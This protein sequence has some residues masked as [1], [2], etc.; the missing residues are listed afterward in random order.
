MRQ[1]KNTKIKKRT[2]RH[3]K[4]RARISGV[5]RTPRLSVFR[6]NKYIYAQLIDDSKG[7]TLVASSD[8]GISGKT[9]VERAKKTG[10]S[11]AE[12]AKGKKISRAVFDRGGFM[13]TGRVKALAE[14][15]REGGLIF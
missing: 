11:L 5:S 12:K 3:N 4:I 8:K 14:G 9:R 15:A 13:Y 2:R 1:V 10:L 7:V 6:S